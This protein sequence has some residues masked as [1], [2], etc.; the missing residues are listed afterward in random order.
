MQ[1]NHKLFSFMGWDWI[2]CCRYWF[3]TVLLI[4]GL[5]VIIVDLEN[6]GKEEDGPAK[7]DNWE[8]DPSKL[9]QLEIGFNLIFSLKDH[10]LQPQCLGLPLLHSQELVKRHLV[11][12]R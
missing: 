1:L 11:W 12:K 7:E 9:E 8:E 10:L 6:V 5:E 3:A 2:K 4:H